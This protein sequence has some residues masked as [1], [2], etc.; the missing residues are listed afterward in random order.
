MTNK[1][2][3]PRDMSFVDRQGNVVHPSKKD[4]DARKSA[5]IG[6]AY[7]FFDCSA[8]YEQIEAELP[9]IRTAVKTPS[10]LELSLTENPDESLMS[11][12]KSASEGNSFNS[13]Y[14][15]VIRAIKDEIDLDEN[16]SRFARLVQIIDIGKESGTK[17][18]MEATYPNSTN[19]QT[20]DEV[21]SVLNQAY[22]SPLYQEGEQF[23]G[24]I[25]YE[26]SGEYLFRE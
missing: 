22:Q 13:E 14:S 24:E 21:A 7:A 6:K 4:Y 20:A 2:E 17:Y 1:K 11:I 25:F 12:A 8:N 26:Q 10:E 16:F 18:V 15:S 3:F 9:N 23:K 5:K 19:K